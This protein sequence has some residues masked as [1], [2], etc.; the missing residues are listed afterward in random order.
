MTGP[1]RN[2]PA[3]EAGQ[4]KREAI[5]QILAAHSPLLPPLTLEQIQAVLAERGIY[6]ATSTIAYHRAAIWE[7]EAIMDGSDSYVSPDKDAA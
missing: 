6:L 1:P 3:Y 2:R 4:Y 5:R 7:Q